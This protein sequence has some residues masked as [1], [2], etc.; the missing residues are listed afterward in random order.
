MKTVLSILEEMRKATFKQVASELHIKP[1][2]ALEM[3]RKERAKGNC[4]FF[5]GFWVLTGKGQGTKAPATGSVKPKTA[6]QRKKTAPAKPAPR[7]E[8][9]TAVDPQIIVQLL[10]QNRAMKTSAI[11][12]AVN[13]AA[14]GMTPVM[15]SLER[16]GLVVRI[17]EGKGTT[18]SLPETQNPA[19]TPIPEAPA[20]E[21]PPPAPASEKSTA[22]IIEAIPAFASRPDDLIIPSSRFISSEIRRTKS[23]LANLQKLQVAV[24]ELRRHK[25]LLVSQQ[26]D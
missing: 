21:T 11:A 2:D 23:K 13:R 26:H 16:Q 4:D 10:Q 9:P 25:N 22:E 5:G 19:E 15:F 20:S 7:G 8:N 3:L 12:A 24:R 6:K 1:V 14:R 17:S 18:W